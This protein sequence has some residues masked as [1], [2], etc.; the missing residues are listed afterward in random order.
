VSSDLSRRGEKCSVYDGPQ[1]SWELTV[2]NNRFYQKHWYLIGDTITK[3]VRGF[4]NA[5]LVP[6]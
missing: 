6:Q 1:Q 4:L 5:V 3:E 2:L